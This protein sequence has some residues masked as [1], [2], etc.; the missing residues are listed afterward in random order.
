MGR[1]QLIGDSKVSPPYK[2]VDRDITPSSLA[3][4]ACPATMSPDRTNPYG[5]GGWQVPSRTINVKANH[6]GVACPELTSKRKYSPS[7]APLMRT[8]TPVWLV[9]VQHE[10]RGRLTGPHA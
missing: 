7:N 6:Y 1:T 3:S 2:I 8:V 10:M 4:A 9:E 5:R